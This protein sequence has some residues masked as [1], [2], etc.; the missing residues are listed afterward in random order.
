MLRSVT[1][2]FAAGNN[3]N[4]RY[5]ITK[6]LCKS[7]NSPLKWKHLISKDLCATKCYGINPQTAS[8]CLLAP[9]PLYL[10]AQTAISLVGPLKTRITPSNAI[11]I[12]KGC[13]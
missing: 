3:M 13:Q 8:P 5:K 10:L 6:A 12:T 9:T 1:K 11:S 4:I 7:Q 2:C